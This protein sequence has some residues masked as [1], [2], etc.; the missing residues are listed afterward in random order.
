[1]ILRYNRDGNK[2]PSNTITI[3]AIST[4]EIDLSFEFTRED[5]ELVTGKYKGTYIEQE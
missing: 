4:D 2:A 3:H 5:G 1:M